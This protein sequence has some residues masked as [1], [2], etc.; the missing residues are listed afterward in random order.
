[1]SKEQERQAQVMESL[2]E[3]VTRISYRVDSHDRDLLQ[4]QDFMKRSTDL[5]TDMREK[6]VRIVDY[7]DEQ[8]RKERMLS[9]SVN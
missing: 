1:M 7:V 5:M 8:K 2:K 4:Q 3:A 6:M 9:R